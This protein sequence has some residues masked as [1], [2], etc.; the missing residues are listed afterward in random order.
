ML[1]IEDVSVLV[2]YVLSLA[3]AA[4]CVVYGVVMWNRGND[5]AQTEDLE[6]AH[7]AEEERRIGED[8]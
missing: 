7:W 3:S 4:L 2:G 1:G 5:G 6:D 8:L